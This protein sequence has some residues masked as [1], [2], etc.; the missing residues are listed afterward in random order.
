MR[1]NRILKNNSSG[2]IPDATSPT[3]IRMVNVSKIYTTQSNRVDALKRI[4]ME[5]CKG[6]FLAVLGRSGSG[7]TTLVN[8]LSGLDKVSSGEVWVEDTPIHRLTEGQAAAWRGKNLGIIFQSFQLISSLTVLQNVTLPM[9]FARL[10]SVRQRR[11]RGMDLLKQ[12]EIDLHAHKLP[13]QLSGGQQQRVAIAR[14]LANNSPLLV[15]DEPTGSLD[16]HTAQS[17]V[18]IFKELANQGKTVVMVTH[19]TDLAG[20]AD[21]AITLSDGELL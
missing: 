4:S 8:V 10:G 1:S 5:I 19:D 2:A 15:A 11:V 12:L 21:R 6:E 13:A 9:D 20:A 14:S 17:V 18:A 16:S 7:K 3:L